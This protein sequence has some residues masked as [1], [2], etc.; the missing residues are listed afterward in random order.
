[1]GTLWFPDQRRLVKG[2]VSILKGP[3]V[4]VTR[5]RKGIG[6]KVSDESTSCKF[7]CI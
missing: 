2:I 1:M 5:L 7:T 3:R 6:D 4:L